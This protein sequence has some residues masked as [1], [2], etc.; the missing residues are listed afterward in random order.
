M[1]SGWVGFEELPKL[2]DGLNLK[3]PATCS[4]YLR[5]HRQKMPQSKDAKSNV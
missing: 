2:P 1:K 5:I 4:E 3:V